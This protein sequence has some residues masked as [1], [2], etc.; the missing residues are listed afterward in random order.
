M[1]GPKEPVLSVKPVRT[2]RQRNAEWK[3]MLGA[4]VAIIIAGSL[5]AIGFVAASNNDS[6]TTCGRL[7][8]GTADGIRS[9]LEAGGPY[10][11]TGG[12]SCSFYLA[13][14][15]SGDI[16]AYAADQPHCTLKQKREKFVCDGKHVDVSTLEKF[17]VSIEEHDKIDVVIVDLNPRSKTTT[18]RGSSPTS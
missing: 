4:A 14:D 1:L 6:R 13:L 8:V 10:F 9:D 15:D 3:L 11:Q 17:P 7:P 16:V 2:R 12:G 5:I 18:S